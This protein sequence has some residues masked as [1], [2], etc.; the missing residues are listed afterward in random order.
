MDPYLEHP[1]YFPNFHNRFIV[2]LEEAIQ[3][4]LPEP[5]YAK[6]EERIWIEWP[7]RAVLPDVTV[8]RSAVR[9]REAVE[10]GTIAV[11]EDAALDTELVEFGEGIEVRELSLHLYAGGPGERGRLV[12]AVELLS[13]SNKANGSDGRAAY[14]RKQAEVLDRDVH[15][16]EMDLLRGGEHTTAIPRRLLRRPF[17]YHVAARDLNLPPAEMYSY[18]IRLED[19]LPRIAVPL[20]PGEGYVVLALQPVFDRCYDT[21]SYRREIDY[22]HDDPEP[23][24]GEPRSRWARECIERWLNP[25]PA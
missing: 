9:P 24:L 11:L 15:L 3:P 22:L 18:P 14:L 21:G 20:L 23:P 25:P 19:P 17:D 8:L 6:T 1:A 12:T 7:Q 16:I 13:P 4:A 5:Y 2:Y 10:S